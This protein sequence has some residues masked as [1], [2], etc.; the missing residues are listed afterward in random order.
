M[1]IY[2]LIL[3]FVLTSCATHSVTIGPLEVEEPI[4]KSEIE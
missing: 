3:S 4:L 2:I 1:K